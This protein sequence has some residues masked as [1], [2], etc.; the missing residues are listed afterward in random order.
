MVLKEMLK[1]DGSGAG[2]PLPQ[3]MDNTAP[4]GAQQ[5]NRKRSSKKLGTAVTAA[6]LL[7]AAL[8]Y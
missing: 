6:P 4:P 8:F 3:E 7:Y 2:S 1:I 5:P